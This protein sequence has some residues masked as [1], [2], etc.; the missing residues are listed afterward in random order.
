MNIPATA[1]LNQEFT[2]LVV[3]KP[4]NSYR[5]CIQGL[6]NEPI[7]VHALLERARELQSDEADFQ[8]LGNYSQAAIVERLTANRL[9]GELSP[10][11]AP[12]LAE[13]V[14]LVAQRRVAACSILDQVSDAEYGV[15]LLAVHRRAT[16]PCTPTSH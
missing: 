4:S 3:I 14:E 12:P 9:R 10:M 11:T 7:T 6:A 5:T 2:D 8:G 13:R 1:V 15:V 16:V